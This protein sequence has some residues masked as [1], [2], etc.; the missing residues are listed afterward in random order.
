MDRDGASMPQRL[1]HIL[2]RRAK[3]ES[4]PASPATSSPSRQTAVAR[5]LEGQLAESIT[6]QE[7]ESMMPQ[8]L[9]LRRRGPSCSTVGGLELEED[10]MCKSPFRVLGDVHELLYT[11]QLRGSLGGSGI[12]PVSN[13]DRSGNGPYS[14]RLAAPPPPDLG[15]RATTSGPLARKAQPAAIAA[16]RSSLPPLPT[17]QV[18][19]LPPL[20]A[21]PSLRPDKTDVAGEAVY[22][23]GI[24]AYKPPAQTSLGLPTAPVADNSP[25]FDKHAAQWHLWEDRW[26]AQERRLAAAAGRPVSR[27][28]MNSMDGYKDKILFQDLLEESQPERLNEDLAFATACRGSGQYFIPLGGIAS[29]PHDAKTH[30]LPVHVR[31]AADGNIV[32]AAKHQRGLRTPSARRAAVRGS[33]P[34]RCDASEA[35]AVHSPERRD[36][37]V[38]DRFRSLPDK[39]YEVMNGTP[40]YVKAVL[41]DA[42]K[43]T[44]VDGKIRPLRRSPNPDA[45]KPKHDILLEAEGL[46]SSFVRQ[47]EQK[48]A[49]QAAREAA[50]RNEGFETQ[51]KPPPPPPPLLVSTA[52][53]AFVAA[54]GS[55]HEQTLLVTNR[56]ATVLLVRA[57][58]LDAAPLPAPDR[59]LHLADQ[60]QDEDDCLPSSER[61]ALGDE[62]TDA[63]SDA[64]YGA[65]GDVPGGQPS[66]AM[67][68]VASLTSERVAGS[69]RL[70][71][72]TPSTSCRPAAPAF[73]LRS[74]EVHVLPGATASFS[75]VFE[76]DLPG[77]YM[78]AVELHTEPA[79]DLAP[80]VVQLSGRCVAHQSN[81]EAVRKLEA[82]LAERQ[83]VAFIRELVLRAMVE[84]AANAGA[85]RVRQ[86][87]RLP[88]PEDVDTPE[89]EPEQ[90]AAPAE[91]A[92]RRKPVKRTKKEMQEAEEAAAA[93]AAAAAASAA[94]AATHP[95]D[96][97]DPLWWAREKDFTAR[98]A[99]L[100]LDFNSA[101]WSALEG[102]AR[103]TGMVNWDGSVGEIEA[104]AADA[105]PAASGLLRELDALL[106]DAL[107]GWR[108]PEPRWR[109]TLLRETVGLTMSDMVDAAAVAAAVR[110]DDPQ[111]PLVHAAAGQPLTFGGA[112]FH[113]SWTELSYYAPPASDG[114]PRKLLEP[115][116]PPPPPVELSAAELAV[117]ATATRNGGKGKGQPKAGDKGKK[118]KSGGA[119]PE[120]SQ[121][122]ELVRMPP[123]TVD[124]G[125]QPA[126]AGPRFRSLM[127][128]LVSAV[129]DACEEV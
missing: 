58:H 81:T 104:S 25:R 19:H 113:W 15:A 35:R 96:G 85:R 114:M 120:P 54:P 61:D 125:A 5:K 86:A 40:A 128:D 67:A 76:A 57:S 48:Q 91:V 10:E 47:R 56:S 100:G 122:P 52:R 2:V 127:L 49:E 64:V 97:V 95:P 38:L 80:V 26:Q 93:A 123:T 46:V 92:N 101:L 37:P 29:R 102:I 21:G 68:A 43:H 82:R 65:A 90:E 126:D 111:H 13:T 1:R 109:D 18:S 33:S 53:L 70:Q 83:K 119:P 27:L 87:E 34:T 75:I 107:S 110:G 72:P 73:V 4:G 44:I 8:T 62:A 55:Q 51:L 60:M 77:A 12:S 117:R 115:A 129:C 45:G 84:P 23:M 105:G 71:K 50:R 89:P 112:P 22:A 17:A 99:A 103:R 108:A 69:A 106:Q 74:T 59:P 121:P 32:S 11:K 31:Q 16:E 20:C 63:P 14:A 28:V 94:E 7:A 98:N 124:A 88:E 66:A 3:D 24:D 79:A 6:A 39:E 116:A 42:R 118:D 36:D 78:H 41:G 30:W 9:A